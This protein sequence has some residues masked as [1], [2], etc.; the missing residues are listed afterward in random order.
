MALNGHTYSSILVN[1][2]YMI[3]VFIKHRLFIRH[4]SVDANKL[5]NKHD[6]NVMIK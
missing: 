6:I 4:D 3:T 1:F 2:V 5:H